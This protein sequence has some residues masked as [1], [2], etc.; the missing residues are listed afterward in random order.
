MASV[1]DYGGPT[2][3]L[4]AVPL[5]G[6]GGWAE[7]VAAALDNSDTPISQRGTFVKKAGDTVNGPLTVAGNVTLGTTPAH[8][9]QVGAG[10]SIDAGGNQ[11]DNVGEPTAASDAATKGYAD[12][13][14][15]WENVW[16][17]GS[18]WQDYGGAFGGMHCTRVGKIVTVSGLIK[19]SSTDLTVNSGTSTTVG[20]LPTGYRPGN[21]VIVPATCSYSGLTSASEW[22]RLNFQ[23]DGGIYFVASNGNKTFSGSG[24]GWIAVAGS[25]RVA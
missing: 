19:R 16:T 14:A 4:A 13:F 18:G 25:F 7:A 5:G 1:N 3:S 21:N 11:I 22:C 8:S 2:D 10:V 24:G 20:T 6:V 12:T 23:S 15:G 17:P 9:V